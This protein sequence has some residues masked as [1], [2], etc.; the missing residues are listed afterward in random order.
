MKGKTVLFIPSNGNH[1]RQFFPIYEILK[2]KYSVLFLTQ[3]SFKNEGAEDA[4]LQLGIGFKKIDG[5]D[6]KEP[7]LILEKEQIGIVVVGNEIDI[8]PQ[9]FIN[10]ATKMGIPSVY[11]QDGL[12]FDYETPNQ[13]TL[14]SL[15][16]KHGTNMKLKK[17]ASRLVIARKIKRVTTHGLVYCTKMHV[18]GRTTE[19]YL[20]GKGVN[21]E[22]ILITGAIQGKKIREI[23][24]QND[25]KSNLVLYA[26][27]DLVFSGIVKPDD[28][29]K[30]VHVACSSLSKLESKVIVKPH[31]SE[32]PEIFNT[33][34]YQNVEVSYQN[35]YYIVPK[36]SL[37]VTDLS[38]FALEALASG[39]PVII[40]FPELAKIVKNNSFPLDLVEKNAVFLARTGDELFEMAGKILGGKL[41]PQKELMNKVVIDYFGQ[42]DGL[43]AVRSANSIIELIDKSS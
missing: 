20:I 30:L 1:V 25:S 19:G 42:M 23:A 15:F 7:E 39:K 33:L 13:S 14:R 37:I 29:R 31:P 16:K 24:N 28:L 17:L 22:N 9:W 6:K 36:S 40:F 43:E 38:S 8:I 4:L 2:E 18:W 3:G 10:T 21:K 11:L 26:P 34:K 32:D 5:Y 27:S 12:L 41:L 35:I